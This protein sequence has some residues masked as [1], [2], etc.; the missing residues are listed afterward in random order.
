MSFRLEFLPEAS[1][2]VECVTGDYEAS[3]AGLG[4]R[5]RSEVESACAAIVQ[6]PLLWRLRPA[7]YRR[8]NLPGFPYYIAFVTDEQ[9]ALVIAVGHSSRHP[10]YFKNRLP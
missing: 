9:Q 7:G 3:S 5:F 1:A 8:V 10:D 2:E 6:H 4:V